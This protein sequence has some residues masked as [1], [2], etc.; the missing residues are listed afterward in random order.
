MATFLQL[1]LNGLAVGCI[2]GL[3]ALG[4]VLIYKAT[5]LVN[6]AQGDL[7]ML[8]AFVA[9]MAIVLWGLD[10]WVGFLIAVAVIAIFGAVLD[11]TVL[12][13]VIGQ[14][15]FAVVML[16]IG[17]GAMFRTFASVTW[18]SEIYTLPTPFSGVTNIAGVTLSHQYLSIIAGTLILCGILYAFF[19]YT[20]IG[21]AMQATSQNQLA[22]YYMGIPVKTDLL[23]GVGDFGW[24]GDGGRHLAGAGNAHR[25]QHGVGRGAQ[26]VRCGRAGRVRLNPRCVGRRH[27]HRPDRALRRS[28]TAGRL[29]GHGTVHR[30]VDNARGAATGPFRNAWT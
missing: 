30:V 22:A 13:R 11:M 21:I 17:L 20:R 24:R 15:Q 18:G 3:V 7:L 9:Y 2:Y 10:Y 5:E 26:G 27:H 1:T 29:Q 19:T 28:D 14:P 23:P 6:F 16:T 8:G 25:H 4:F 12:R